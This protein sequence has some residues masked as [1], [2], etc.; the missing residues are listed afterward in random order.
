[1][2]Q[3]NVSLTEAKTYNGR[4]KLERQSFLNSG[5]KQVTSLF[6]DQPRIDAQ[7]RPTKCENYMPN[8][9]GITNICIPGVSVIVPCKVL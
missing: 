3:D 6:V 9:K 4:V 2:I 1:M 7:H 5:A 8:F